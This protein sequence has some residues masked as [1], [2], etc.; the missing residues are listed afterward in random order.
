MFSK[1]IIWGFPLHSH[2]H[3]YIHYGWYKAFKR[4]GYDTYWF[5]DKN[6]PKDF[7]YND[8]LFITEGY[9]DENIPVMTTS[10]YFVHIARNLEKYVHKVKRFVEIRY[11]VDSIKDCNYN[12]TLDKS[13]CRKISDCTYYEL[14]FDN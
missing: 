11:L 1:V 5:D 9:A 8:C 3:S 7:D 2:T 6:Y 14:L 10:I 4:I 13:A 12:Y